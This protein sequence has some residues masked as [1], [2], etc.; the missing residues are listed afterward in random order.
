[1]TR[2]PTRSPWFRVER[3]TDD[4]TRVDEPHVHELLR[5]NIWQLRGRDRDL[6][7]DA[8]LGV[9]SLRAHVPR[10][11]ERDPVLVLT[12]RHLDHVGS[13]H[14]FGDRRMHAATEVDG[15]PAS[16]RGPELAMLLGLEWPDAPALLIDGVPSE[17]FGIDDYAIPPAPA[18]QHLADGDVVDLG[19]RRLRV[20]HLPG[21]TPGCL[22]LF[23]EQSGALFSGDVVYDDVL[24][25]ELP[26]SDIP[27]YLD[28][29][30]RLRSLPV[31][32]VY[33]GHG[34][35]FPGARLTEL[36]DA[37]LAARSDH[38]SS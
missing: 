9:A 27:A 28:S 11:F 23:D 38:A 18:T 1:V 10:L 19:D 37:Y 36:V 20:V 4:L 6:V 24:L 3:V 15:T 32:I 35:P 5:A 25:D 8:G 21:H 2:L 17:T 7:V 14:E 22:C 29:M 26:E 34:D 31:E 13:A 16:L 33:P 12:H 30:R